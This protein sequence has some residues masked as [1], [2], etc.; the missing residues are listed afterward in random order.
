MSESRKVTMPHPVRRGKRNYLNIN[1]YAT[2][3][4]ADDAVFLLGGLGQLDREGA[5]RRK[6]LDADGEFAVAS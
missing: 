3:G 4:D 5:G 6:D 2:E 1:W